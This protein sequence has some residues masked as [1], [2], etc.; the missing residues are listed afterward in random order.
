MVR[1]MRSK[2]CY[3]IQPAIHYADNKSTIAGHAFYY[4]STSEVKVVFDPYE[5]ASFAD[6]MKTVSIK[7]K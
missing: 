1:N 4:T 6:G 2:K 7:I 3:I 5:L